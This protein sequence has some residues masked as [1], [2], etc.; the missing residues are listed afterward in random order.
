MDLK[1]ATTLKNDIELKE[2]E[3][4]QKNMLKVAELI[5]KKRR[6]NSICLFFYLTVE[7]DF[8]LLCGL[9][10]SGTMSVAVVFTV[11]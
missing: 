3:S 4:T 10:M 9:H 5:Q 1:S 6:D 11:A 8:N 7:C 2:K